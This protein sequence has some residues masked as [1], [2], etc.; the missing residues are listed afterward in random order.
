MPARFRLS[1]RLLI[2]GRGSP[3]AFPLYT[4]PEFEG[5]TLRA[6]RRCKA[7][8]GFPWGHSARLGSCYCSA[9]TKVINDSYECGPA[10]FS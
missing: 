5:S 3:L 1:Y 2:K 8:F 4:K 6:I 9:G 10:G 7:D